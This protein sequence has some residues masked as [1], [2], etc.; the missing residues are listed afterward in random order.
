MHANQL[1]GGAALVCQCFCS[2]LL[3]SFWPGI[4]WGNLT[5]P[6]ASK[7]TVSPSN[8]ILYSVFRGGKGGGSRNSSYWVGT[9]QIPMANSIV[10]Y[11]A[12][13]R[14]CWKCGGIYLP[15]LGL[16]PQLF[17]KLFDSKLYLVKSGSNYMT[18][19]VVNTFFKNKKMISLSIYTLINREVVLSSITT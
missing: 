4:G 7:E 17:Y 13:S 2:G 11:N 6:P 19:D 12:Y 14:W 5:V 16:N 18:F 9:H 8:P 10:S 3:V 1:R 15:F